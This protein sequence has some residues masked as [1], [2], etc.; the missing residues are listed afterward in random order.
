MGLS[1]LLGR[2]RWRISL[3]SWTS[4]RRLW[5]SVLRSLLLFLLPANRAGS[6]QDRHLCEWSRRWV[7]AH[8]R[9]RLSDH[10][11]HC[12]VLNRNAHLGSYGVSVIPAFYRRTR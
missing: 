3:P 9:I 5:R 12:A 11:G 1:G 8:G 7:P 2:R 6:V 10:F 4:L